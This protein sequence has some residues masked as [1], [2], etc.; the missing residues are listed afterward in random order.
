[1]LANT[2]ETL[3]PMPS[4]RFNFGAQAIGNKIYVLGGQGH[5]ISDGVFDWARNVWVYNIDTNSWSVAA[6]TMPRETALFGCAEVGGIIYVLNGSYQGGNYSKTVYAYDTASDTWTTKAQTNRSRRAPSAF[7][8]GGIVYLFSG[9]SEELGQAFDVTVEAYN[10]ETNT[11]SPKANILHGNRYA[12]SGVAGGKGYLI[13]G[14]T[15]YTQSYDPDVNVWTLEPGGAFP[16]TYGHAGGAIGN[17]VYSAGG[18]NINGSVSSVGWAFDPATDTYTGIAS[19]PTPRG[20]VGSTVAKGHLYVLGGQ[21]ASPAYLNKNERYSPSDDI[22]A[23]RV[24]SA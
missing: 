7:A 12:A 18:F 3:A 21:D 5:R 10:P 17:K 13:G 22:V 2:W 1:M 6:S 19:I 14:E 16:P 15:G 8:I 4:T 9:H 24:G 11:W 20:W 23:W